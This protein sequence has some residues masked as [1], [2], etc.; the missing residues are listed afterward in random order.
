MASHRIIIDCDPGH[1][2]MAA[3]VLAAQHADIR[4][5]AIT[6][7]C[8]NAPVDKTT[9]NALRIVSALGLD[10]PVHA[11]AVA[12]LRHRYD[13]PTQFHGESG[14]DSAG[15]DLPATTRPAHPLYAVDAIIGLADRYPG[16]ITVVAIGPMTNLALALSRRPDLA[17]LLKQVVF[18]GGSTGAGNVTQAAEFNIWA[19]PEAADRVFRSGVK[20]V[21]FG[22]NVTHQTE[23]GRDDVAAIRT[24]GGDANPFADIMQFYCDVHYA[25]AGQDAPGAPLHDPCAI[26]YLI[27]PELFTLDAYRGDVVTVEGVEY[28]RTRLAPAAVGG[29]EPELALMQV[30]IGVD[31]PRLAAMVT[32]ALIG[33]SRTQQNQAGDTGIASFEGVQA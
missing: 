32:Q 22:L 9:R 19:D 8:G 18:M 4:I 23:F 14:L 10:V 20:L 28:G 7:V 11:G 27:D 24:G 12:A 30:A 33:A 21:M 1:D 29:A 15:A 26:A 13:F 2:D 3:I 17:G 25:Y 16:E 31:A 5:E 6:S